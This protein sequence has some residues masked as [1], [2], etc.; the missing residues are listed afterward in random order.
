MF[1]EDPKVVSNGELSSQIV[2]RSMMVNVHCRYK[3]GQLWR[4]FVADTTVVNNGESSSKTLKWSVIAN[5][6]REN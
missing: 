3:S 4:I 2:K 5:F 6:Q 1:I